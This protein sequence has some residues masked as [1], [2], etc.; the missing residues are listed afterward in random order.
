[1]AEQQSSSNRERQGLADRPSCA[2]SRT[3]EL[4]AAPEPPSVP[5]HSPALTPDA[6]TALL[7]IQAPA[8]PVTLKG[9]ATQVQAFPKDGP[10]KAYY[11]RLALGGASVRFHVDP[12]SPPA[13]GEHCLIHGVL[14][15]KATDPVGG[16]KK[17]W[18]ATHE[19]MLRGSVV[20]RW[21]PMPAASARNGAA[22]A[23]RR[24]SGRLPLSAWVEENDLQSLLIIASD[25]GKPDL[26][27]G[28]G[29]RRQ[30]LPL[31]FASGR[32]GDAPSFLECLD[33]IDWSG[34]EGVAI[35]RGGGGGLDEVGNAPE[36][37]QAFLD[38]GVTFYSA[39][40]HTNSVCLLDKFADQAFAVP[41]A[42]GTALAEALNDLE[43][44]RHREDRWKHDR[45]EVQRLQAAE[46]ARAATPPSV[47]AP[48]V[49]QHQ[50]LAVRLTPRA[51][52][53]ALL[54]LFVV[55]LWGRYGG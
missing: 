53:A 1:M 10:P 7:K 15:I 48:L 30:G 46:A 45:A 44:N 39:V 41:H 22:L 34:V 36:V 26:W 32:F 2:S 47:P 37:V 13:V 54:V 11:G 40:G 12:E 49:P 21:Q 35:V 6:L 3:V 14:T 42:F 50:P 38:R 19:L 17:E 24:E 51:I 33:R 16:D 55:F 28:L 18:R 5:E 9:I 8:G 25:E 4:T 43:A 23:L 29:A 20:G 31:R 27:Q 52:G